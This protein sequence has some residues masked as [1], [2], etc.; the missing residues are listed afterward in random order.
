M[1]TRS[2]FRS[3]PLHL[4]TLEDRAVPATFTVTTVAD[5]GS[6]ITPTAGSLREAIVKANATAGADIIAFNIAG[7]GVQVI[8]PPLA[9]PGI[10]EAVVVDGTT[11]PGFA[12]TPVIRLAGNSAGTGTQGLNLVNHTGTTIKSVSIGGFNGPGIRISGG[13]G[14]SILGSLIGT[15]QNGSA[16]AGNSTGIRLENGAINTTIGGAGTNERNT[17]SG[18][19]GAGIVID[20]AYNTMVSGNF[21]GTDINGFAKVANGG[22][23]VQLTNG[24]I[25]N[26]IGGAAPGLGNVIAGNTLA[27]VLI[28]GATTNN[29]FI[30]GNRI[31]LDFSGSPLGNL[32]AG[33]QA[34]SGAGSNPAGG[35]SS[36]TITAVRNNSIAGNS[37]AG[38]AILD[39]S[40]QIRVE[41]NSIRD[42]GGLGI[43]REGSANNSLAAPV[44]ATLKTVNGGVSVSGTIAGRPDTKYLVAVYT[45]PTQDASGFGEGQTP[46]TLVTVTTNA[47]GAGT[48][49][50]TLSST[51]TGAFVSTLVIDDTLGD[52]SSFSNTRA[53]PDTLLTNNT[54]AAGGGA[55][56]PPT[57]VLLDPSGT[58]LSTIEFFENTFTGGIRVATG[59]VNGDGVPDL[60][61][62]SG[63]G[64]KAEVRLINSITKEL[65][66]TVNPF[67]EF[68]RGCYVAMGDVNKDGAADIIVTP[69]EGGGPRVRVFNGKTFS[70]IADFFGIQDINFRGGARAAVGDLNN[71]QFGDVIVSAGF[72]GGPRV[73]AFSGATLTTDGGP[74]LFGDFFAFEQSLRNGAFVT[75]A[76]INGD[77]FAE[78]IAAAGPGGAPR[79][80]AF[81]GKTL[82]TSSGQTLTTIVDFFA[83]DVNSRGGVRIFAR[84]LN[85][86][87]FAEIYAAD[88]SG[89][90]IRRYVGS[91]LKSGLTDIS[92]QFNVLQSRTGGIFVG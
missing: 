85:G 82:I 2:F 15:T 48:F 6:N 63:V 42:N 20:N 39:T 13:A 1:P 21:I 77:G 37:G 90:S 86:D 34:S 16:P 7:G 61:V 38:V 74:K 49:D 19:T 27:G 91:G 5:N 58:T 36:D 73:A 56:G 32:G 92:A 53:R 22:A 40:R 44:L 54:F 46:V 66:F 4:V 80:K 18:N 67:G 47:S 45:N 8:S 70:Q 71:D 25:G 89:N 69:D 60:A 31:G 76:D 30:L 10:T 43:L 65:L 33:V 83:G 24:A 57:A 84:D 55:G 51:T 62:A 12:G 72:G 23:G 64:R 35:I 17:I 9:L 79:V 29:N 50:Y 68:T 26:L 3:L 75:A 59:D 87:G 81:N 11:Q 88:A 28:E 52:T 78:L 14:H 41:G